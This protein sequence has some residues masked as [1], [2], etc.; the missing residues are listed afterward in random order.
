MK[1]CLCDEPQLLIKASVQDVVEIQEF[2][3]TDVPSE[4]SGNKWE[5]EWYERRTHRIG[6]MRKKGLQIETSDLP[7]L[8]VH[9]REM[10]T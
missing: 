8:P 1:I 10:V 4:E 9:C 2:R 6:N 7:P 5:K 3:T